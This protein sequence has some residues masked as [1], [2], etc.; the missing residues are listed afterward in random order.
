MKRR[1]FIVKTG[2]NALAFS[3]TLLL[4]GNTP[5][6]RGVND[7]VKVVVIGINGMG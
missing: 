6:W 1:K 4:W 2:V 3:A 7:K 5:T